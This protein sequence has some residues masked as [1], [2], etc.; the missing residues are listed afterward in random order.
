[1]SN[2]ATAT[3]P[4]AP[5]PADPAKANSAKPKAPEA[6]PAPAPTPTPKAFDQ[7]PETD[8]KVEVQPNSAPAPRGGNSAYADETTRQQVVELM[9]YLRKAGFTRPSISAVT[10][11][12]DSQV[13]RAQ[14]GKVHASEV[15]ALLNFAKAAEA[16]EIQPPANGVRKPK[17]ADLEAQINGLQAKIDAATA[18][19]AELGEKPNVAQLRA[20]VKDVQATLA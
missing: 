16:G 11:Y 14:N 4:A 10:G 17:L 2:T 20:A 9:A 1:M 6:A 12:T 19:L 7:V 3:K 13:W 18:K 15:E 8:A 5:K